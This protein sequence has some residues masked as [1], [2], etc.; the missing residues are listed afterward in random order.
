MTTLRAKITKIH[1]ENPLLD[2]VEVAAL[3]GNTASRVGGLSSK[4]NIGIPKVSDEK[5]LAIRKATATKSHAIQK[6]NRD[7][8]AGTPKVP[9]KGS[10]SYEVFEYVRNNPTATREAIML[11]VDVDTR[12]LSY[13]TYRFSLTIAGEPSGNS[14]VAATRQARTR[15]SKPKAAKV[16]S[17]KPVVKEPYVESSK[18][19]FYL[20]E[21]EGTG[22]YLHISCQG[23]T[24][25]VAYA[26]N[27]SRPRMEACMAKYDVAKNLIPNKLIDLGKIRRL[28]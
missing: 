18:A 17:F 6:K 26:W 10:K 3:V 1:E 22:K 25:D 7:A 2:T 5:R 27:D 15:T 20:R 8:K 16:V 28:A 21:G 14:N 13:I 11:A 12:S 24:D 9:R 4:W 23:L 19:K